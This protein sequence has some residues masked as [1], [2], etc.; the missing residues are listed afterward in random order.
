MGRKIKSDGLENFSGLIHHIPLISYLSK[1]KR[2][3]IISTGIAKLNEV[4]TAINAVKSKGN[5]KIVLYS[6]RQTTQ[7]KVKI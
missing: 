2:P 7:L 4:S 6:V 3:M 1:F 5:K